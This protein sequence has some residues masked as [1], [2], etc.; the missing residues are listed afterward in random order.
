MDLWTLFYGF[1][2]GVAFV[3]LFQR[4]FSIELKSPKYLRFYIPNSMRDGYL[5]LPIGMADRMMPMMPPMPMPKE[6]P[7]G[8]TAEARGNYL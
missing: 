8:D 1:L 4:F 6:K 7:K 2:G 3:L 5:E